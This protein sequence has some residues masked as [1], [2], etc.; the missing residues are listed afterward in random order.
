[1]GGYSGNVKL[2]D[3]FFKNNTAGT[4]GGAVYT[5]Y[6]NAVS[7]TLTEI[8]NCAFAGNHATYGGAVYT[9]QVSQVSGT[10]FNDNTATDGDG[11]ALYINNKCDPKFVSCKFQNNTCNNRGGGIYLDSSNSNL[12][13]SNCTFTDNSANKGGAIYASQ[14]SHISKSLFLR[15]KVT[16][17][18]ADGGA[19][20]IN[21]KCIHLSDIQAIPTFCSW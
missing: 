7:Y 14:I 4:Y 9:S 15:N 16:G 10:V 13:F 21:N 20:Y 1:M 8:D 19:I 17:T 3:S 5:N 2:S 6:E 11:G 18:K 12:E